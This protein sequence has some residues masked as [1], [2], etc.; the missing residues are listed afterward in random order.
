MIHEVDESLRSFIAS[1]PANDGIEVSFDPPNRDWS[2]RRSG[3]TINV[4][5]YDIR[6]DLERRNAWRRSMMDEHGRVV[7]RRDS[8][9]MFK[10]AY[11]MSAWTQRP[12]DEH[13][14]LSILLSR[15]LQVDVL[16]EAH[17]RGSLATIE[18]PTLLKL[19]APAGPDRSATDLWG[20]LGG[21]LK[22]SL[23]LT[24]TAPLDPERTYQGGPPVVEEP[25][26]NIGEVDERGRTLAPI[27]APLEDGDGD[28]VVAGRTVPG[29][30]FRIRPM[31]R[32]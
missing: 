24:V 12:E 16:P 13:R 15:F 8:V 2:A 25:V 30:T 26:L 7:G 32:P 17:L 21:E 22:P 19:A 28:E 14:V 10:L 18:V 9:R 29:R 27:V 5:L 3:P 31:D 1:D 20:A 11:L 4:F 23:D 6:E